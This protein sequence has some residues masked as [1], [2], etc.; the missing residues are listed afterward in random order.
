MKLGGLSE[1]AEALGVSRQRVS[2]LRDRPDFPDPIGELAQGAIWDLDAVRAWNDSG[3]RSAPG[4]PAAALAART[5]GGRFVLE[6]KIGSGGFAD[7]YRAKDRKHAGEPAAVKVLR[8]VEGVDLEALRRFR[9]ELRILEGLQHPHVIQVLAHGDTEDEGIWYAMPLAQGSLDDALD[10][11]A[12]QAAEILAIVR[13]VCAGLTHLHG[14]GI[15][16]RDLKPA[17]ILRIG[18]GWA[19]SDFGLAAELQR[20]TTVL[21]S[22]GREGLGS[23]WYTA[24]EQWTSARDADHLAD[25]YSLGKV[26]QELLTGLPPV[27]SDLPASPLRPVIERATAPRP[28][29]RHQSVSDLL[30]AV[31]TALDAPQGRRW[32]STEET[33]KRLLELVRLPKPAVEDLD[34][35]LAWAESLDETDTEEMRALTRVL[36]WTSSWS[37]RTMWKRDRATFRRIFARYCDHVADHGFAF[38]YCDVLADFTRRVVQEIDSSAMLRSAVQALAELGYGHNRWHVRDVLVALLQSMHDDE[39]AVASVEGLRAAG[40]G[41]TDWSVQNF[42]LRSLHPTLR[43]AIEQLLDEGDDDE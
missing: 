42:S 40:P 15:F 20:A 27:T 17:N 38:D 41:A 37:I 32:E 19:I 26:L 39:S 25:I 29:D 35:L 24:P 3:L 5:M 13:Q 11:V 43:G 6:E 23:Y 12:G 28:R 8:D 21:T 22:T 34:D 10:D 7:V 1:V 2:R 30:T 14:E 31:E 33:A 9:R 4:R 16:H 18:Q 36:P